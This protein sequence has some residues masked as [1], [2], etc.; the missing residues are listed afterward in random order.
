MLLAHTKLDL[1]G[2]ILRS[3]CQAMPEPRAVCCSATSPPRHAASASGCAAAPAPARREI[4]GRAARPICW[5]TTMGM[6]FWS[7]GA[8]H[9][10]RRARCR[11]NPWLGGAPAG[12]P[13]STD[14]ELAA[15]RGSPAPPDADAQCALRIDGAARARIRGLSRRRSSAP[16]SRVGRPRSAVPCGSRWPRCSDTWTRMDGTRRQAARR[17]AGE[18][19]TLGRCRRSE[20]HW[21]SAVAQTVALTDSL[22][23]AH[24]ATPAQRVA[25][26]RRQGLRSGRRRA[27]SRTGWRAGAAEHAV[28]RGPLG[29][30]R[31]RRS[32][33]VGCAT[34]RRQL[35][36]HVL[37]GTSS[38]RQC[39]RA[40]LRAF[41][42]RCR[43]AAVDVRARLVARPQ[44]RARAA[45]FR[46]CWCYARARSA[47]RKRGSSGRKSNPAAERRHNA[48]G[49]QMTTRIVR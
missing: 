37:A 26:R 31:R 1:Q 30:A 48:G 17:Y 18:I 3:R 39:G 43:D 35:T 34:T 23:V 27:R 6:T 24:I 28:G 14:A 15:A 8:R 16:D 19:G 38:R 29:S 5:S 42:A 22:E 2:R 20:R 45:Y 41:A 13:R 11:C 33:R 49:G 7:G 40:R 10:P 21:R 46:R 47:R 36:L 4:I 32:P 25:A 44:G 12:R 9:R